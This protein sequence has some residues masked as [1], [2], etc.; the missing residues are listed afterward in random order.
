MFDEHDLTIT[1][2]R[3]DVG[4]TDKSTKA[5]GCTGSYICNKKD[6]NDESETV[7]RSISNKKTIG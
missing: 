3:G 6:V 1:C 7:F 2:L 5:Q 4:K